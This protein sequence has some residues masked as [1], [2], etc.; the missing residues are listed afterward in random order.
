[1]TSDSS[2]THFEAALALTIHDVKNSLAL[3]LDRVEVIQANED[4][5]NNKQKINVKIVFIIIA[6]LQSLHLANKFST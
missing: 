3:F 6:L 1:M 4:A 2:K 5:A